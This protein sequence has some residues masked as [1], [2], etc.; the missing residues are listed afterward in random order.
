MINDSLLPTANKFYLQVLFI[1][2]LTPVQ[3]ASF[4]LPVLIDIFTTFLYLTES[5][6]KGVKSLDHWRGFCSVL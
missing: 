3:C 5:R 6:N 4:L 1:I 2:I